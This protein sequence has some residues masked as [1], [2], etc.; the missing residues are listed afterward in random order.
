M[1]KDINKKNST[2]DKISKPQKEIKFYITS[3]EFVEQ[4]IECWREGLWYYPKPC[5]G[6]VT[7]LRMG[8]AAM[9]TLLEIMKEENKN[10]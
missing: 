7:T 3:K 5:E 9:E 2:S 6:E 4:Q 10:D 1:N 8:I